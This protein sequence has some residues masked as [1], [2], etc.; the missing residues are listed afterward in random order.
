VPALKAYRLNPNMD[1]VLDAIRT[2]E[3]I[4]GEEG[5]KELPPQ[6]SVHHPPLPHKTGPVPRDGFPGISHFLLTA[7]YSVIIS[8]NR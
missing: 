1:G 3:N 5:D 2:L 7:H 6:S 4:L 8:Q